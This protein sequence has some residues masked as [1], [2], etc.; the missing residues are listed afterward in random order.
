MSTRLL[1]LRAIRRAELLLSI[2]LSI[3]S[4]SF[5][6][7]AQ[8]PE[9][10]E[11]KI[12]EAA[13]DVTG[14]LQGQD[15]VRIQ[16]MCTHCN[17]SNI[18]VGGLSQDLV[19][20]EFGGYPLFG[21]LATS[22]VMSMLPPDTVAEA[23][24]SKGPGEAVD[25]SR[26]AGGTIRLLRATP[27]ELPWFDVGYDTG[28]FGRQTSYLR[29]SGPVTRWLSGSATVGKE[30]ADAV[31]DDGDG[32]VD[33]AAADRK[34]A[35]GE[36][37]IAPSKSHT[38]ELSGS[39]I[40]E[41]DLNS[42]GAFDANVFLLQGQKAAWTREDALF[43]RREY[44]AGW[45]WDLPRGGA[46]HLRG[47]SAKREQTVR[48]QETALPGFNELFDRY[49]ID[50]T[51]KWGELRLDYPI[52]LSWAVSASAERTD[53]EVTANEFTPLGQLFQ[54]ATDS[55]KGWAYAAQ[56]QRVI[57]QKWTVTAGLRYDDDELYGTSRSPRL[58]VLYRP[59]AGMML[60]FVAGRTFRPPKP[61]FAEVCC[62]RRYLTNTEAGVVAE[63]AWTYAFEAGYQPSPELKL[64]GYVAQTSFDE[65]VIQLVAES[66][67]YRQIYGNTN[68]PKARARTLEFAG[69]WTPITPLTLDASIGW[70]VFRN[71]G[72]QNVA[73]TYRPFFGGPT[74]LE[75]RTLPIDRIPYRPSRSASV[76][77]AWTLPRGISLRG[78]GAYTG[79]Q[80]IQQY[81]A[82]DPMSVNP[83]KL[84]LNDLREV[85][86]FWLWNLG[87][88]APLGKYIEIQAGI[89][90]IGDY[91][92]EDLGDYTRDYNWGPLTGR[93][94]RLGLKFHLDRK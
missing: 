94:W 46:V 19:P 62:G 93:S 70:L 21:G 52:N 82:W 73:I 92:Q 79:P 10:G 14:S 64:S 69:K 28:S 47:S 9:Q 39:Y 2:F 3:A 4:S 84:L 61:T 38:I 12:D 50:E 23:K 29:G 87:L 81:A 40:D 20:L 24:V 37:R 88:T 71:T 66:A 18:Q 56:A 7:L 5:I 85:P 15:G 57:G 42:R 89:D 32:W 65:H 91:I 41:T 74:A 6:T 26:A 72:D 43:V 58:T 8:Q 78:S 59:I 25:P 34:L 76:G 53:E 31:D 35:D 17:S 80:L 90:N 30:T 44:R 45:T 83:T 67:F 49:G 60:R 36:L 1:R 68:V 54:S 22:F 75:T 48:S 13:G 27:K 63:Q 77:V 11:V 86:D 51:S 16:T 55:V 33:V